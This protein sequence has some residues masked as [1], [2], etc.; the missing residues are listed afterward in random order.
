MQIK[1]KPE[2]YKNQPEDKNQKIEIK[3][4]KKYNPPSCMKVRYSSR[5]ENKPH[6]SS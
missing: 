4:R 6:M 3:Y 1:G 2:I 5:R